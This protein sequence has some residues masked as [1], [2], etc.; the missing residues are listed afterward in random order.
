MM[1][2]LQSDKLKY[3]RRSHCARCFNTIKRSI[4]SLTGKWVDNFSIKIRNEVEETW[5]TRLQK[6][7]DT[8]T[9]NKND[10]KPKYYVL[11]MFPYPSGKLHMG[12]VRVYTISD[13]MAHFY[14][15]NGKQ[16]LH[17][18]GWDSFGLPAENAAIERGL[19]PDDW[20][21]SNIDHMKNQLKSLSMCFNWEREVMTC[22]PDYYRWTQ[23]IFVRLFEAG[24]AYQKEGL[25]NWDPVDQTVLANEQVDEDGCSWR[26]GAKVEQKV[27]R[28]WY[29][30]MTQ[31]SKSLL[32]GLEDL[33]DWPDSIKSAQAHFIGDCSGCSFSFT[34]QLP[35]IDTD[36]PVYVS[37]PE[38]IFG[39]SYILISPTHTL[40]KSESLLHS[41]QPDV[42]NA[43]DEIDSKQLDITLG[44][45]AIHP[46]TKQQI[47]LI[48][49]GTHSF[50][51]YVEQYAGIPSVFEEDQIFANQ[52][53]FNSTIVIDKDNMLINSDEFTGMNR[54]EAKEAIMQKARE[55]G[56]GGHMTSQR[57]C[58]WLISRQRYWGAP[59]PIIHCKNC[60]AVPVPI[61]QLPVE[62]PK[63]AT[64]TGKGKSAL[65]QVPEW[66]NS[67]CPKCGEPSQ[68]EMDTM[69]T[70][71]DSSWYYLRFT[72]PHNEQEEFNREIANSLMPVDLYIGGEEHAILHL[73]KAR[74]ISHFLHSQG[75][76]E[77]KEPFK[78]LLVHGLVMG[79]SYMLPSTGQYLTKE[80]I[81]FS[82]NEPVEKVSKEKLII[83]FEK[84]S[85]S[86]HNGVDP[87][88][89]IAEH[90]ID[91][92]RLF[93][94]S[95]VPPQRNMMWNV[96]SIVGIIRWKNK[97]WQLISRHIKLK[98]DSKSNDS[99]DKDKDLQILKKK[100]TAIK[101]V[102]Q[103]YINNYMLSVAI[104]RLIT[105]TKVLGSVPDTVSMSSVEYEDALASLCV[106]LA[107][108]APHIA[109][110]MWQ[111]LASVA[112]P[113]SKY[114]WDKT[115]LEQ[116]WPVLE[117]YSTEDMIKVFIKVNHNTKGYVMVPRHLRDN[118]DEIQK[119]VDKSDLGKSYL[120]GR[121]FTKVVFTSK[122][123]YRSMIFVS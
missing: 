97:M 76:I 5:K 103:Q 106:M 91:T 121:T 92:M 14:R 21:F 30:K 80:E 100:N 78:R 10:K 38:L 68:R 58:D 57:Q 102:S 8:L 119:L 81:D 23:S 16:V 118:Q 72:D 19:R 55:Q 86:K 112:E 87:I 61:N 37:N 110:E 33:K 64:L 108:M 2:L 67:T 11:S 109:S 115:V 107:P 54:A 59:I 66:Y 25:V 34:L 9:V 41:V 53:G 48:A 3:L 40:L 88:D 123:N 120:N 85:K 79:P 65:Q 90:G 84:M 28:Q 36:L 83:K 26:S 27:L 42:R 122:V 50:P 47:P 113:S 99:V 4:Y 63:L 31:Y 116:N 56:I 20:T 60:K 75:L 98:K 44:V 77:H 6:Y 101:E 69:D 62:L 52:H 51:K 89:A 114:Q 46:F 12:H 49:S 95:G 29:L 94:L 117:E 111:G 93:I 45:S 18:M 105:L 35:G 73:L 104:T 82:G 43:L 7:N 13:T 22:K 24:L 70:F 32:D 17:P 1:V 39:V 71:V 74:F 15:M 96:D